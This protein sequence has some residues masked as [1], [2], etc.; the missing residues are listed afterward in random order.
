MES[1]LNPP[2]VP[3]YWV[4]HAM[5]MEQKIRNKVDGLHAIVKIRIAAA[6]VEAF[7][8]SGP[9]WEVFVELSLNGKIVRTM[10]GQF[11]PEEEQRGFDRVLKTLFQKL[12]DDFIIT[13]V[14]AWYHNSL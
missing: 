5:D 6:K 10:S 12:N 8:G 13:A 7:F 14:Q 4:A 9:P 3:Q 11:S 2:K 1:T